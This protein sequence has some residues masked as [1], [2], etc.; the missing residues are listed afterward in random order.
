MQPPDDARY[1]TYRADERPDV[2][3]TLD[4][5]DEAEG[6][7]R[8]WKRGPD[9]WVG[10]VQWRRGPGQGTRTGDFAAERIREDDRDLT[11]PGWTPELKR[12]NAP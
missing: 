3:V 10:S 1:R 12:T 9:G 4:D 6:E 7:L 5:G 8:A 2:L 11:P